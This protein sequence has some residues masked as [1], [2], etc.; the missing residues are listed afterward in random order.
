MALHRYRLVDLDEVHLF[1]H[2][3]YV[4]QIYNRIYSFSSSANVAS[5]SFSKDNGA[6]LYL[7]PSLFFNP[8]H[9]HLLLNLFPLF[10]SFFLSLPEFSGKSC[11]K[12]G[13]GLQHPSPP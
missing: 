11:P 6:C 9:T 8:S 10:S 7:Y 4:N 5:P 2:K 1:Q 12:K 13:R 3:N